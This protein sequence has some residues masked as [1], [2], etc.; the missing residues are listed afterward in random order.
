MPHLDG[1]DAWEAIANMT[2]AGV[3]QAVQ[4]KML[5]ANAARLY[6]IEPQ[7]FVTEAPQEY[8][9]MRMPRLV[10]AG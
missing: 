6:G 2:K 3:P 10:T 8:Q 7:L 5:G 9:P 4:E 1:S